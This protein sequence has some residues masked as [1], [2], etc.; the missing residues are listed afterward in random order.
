[1]ILPLTALAPARVCSTAAE[2]ARRRSAGPGSWVANTVSRAALLAPGLACW[3]T[4]NI[5][6]R[7]E[8][9]PEISFDQANQAHADLLD[10]D[11]EYRPYELLPP[12]HGTIGATF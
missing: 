5:M 3:E 11:V 6:R 8:L 2:R 1:V 9:R 4:A 7:Y 12:A 10:L